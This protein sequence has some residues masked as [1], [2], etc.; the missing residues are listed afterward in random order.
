MAATSAVRVVTSL[1]FLVG[2]SLLQAEIRGAAPAGPEIIWTWG[3]EGWLEWNLKTGRPRL[4]AK[5]DFGPGGCAGDL[6]GNGRLTLLVQEKNGT[7]P[8]VAL[9]PG[10]KREVIEPE[11][12]FSDCLITSLNGRRGVLFA[13]FFS[14]LR[15][16]YPVQKDRWAAEEVYSI[17]TASRQG[18]LLQARVDGD[19]LDDLFAGNYWVRN[20]GQSGVPWRIFAINLWHE[21]PLAAQARLALLGTSLVWAESQAD[22]ARVALFHPPADIHQLWTATPLPGVYRRP[23]GVAVA[24][25][26]IWIGDQ[27]RI[28]ELREEAGWAPRTLAVGFSTVQLFVLQD[29]LWAVTETKV[30]AV[31]GADMHRPR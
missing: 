15:L 25:G 20:P 4:L 3:D 2:I 6:H 17:Y 8:L 9:T 30:R 22:P 18:G 28:V 13:H 16:Y 12:E 23:R 21:T 1:L 11:T 10:G 14:Q 7:G 27:S 26:R 19:A 31:S 5:G 24:L 29:R